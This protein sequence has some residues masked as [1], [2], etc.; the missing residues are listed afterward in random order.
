MPDYCPSCNALIPDPGEAQPPPFLLTTFG[1]GM[2]GLVSTAYAAGAVALCFFD[3]DPHPGRLLL[4]ALL[5]GIVGAAAARWLGSRLTADNRRGFERFLM[6]AIIASFTGAFAAVVGIRNAY[7]LA[8]LIAIASLSLYAYLRRLP[9][10]WGHHG[11][12]RDFS[13]GP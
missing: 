12:R 9:P 2:T 8:A 6:A 4:W 5:A 13:G 10:E 11:D 7:V 3:D 1:L